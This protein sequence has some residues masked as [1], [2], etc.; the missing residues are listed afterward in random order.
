[1]RHGN[2]LNHL[3]RKSA[4]RKALMMNLAINLIEHKHIVTTTAKAKALRGYVEPLITKSKDNTTHS[5]RLVFS[6]LKNKEAVST[7]FEEVAEKIATRAGGYT[8]IIKLEPRRGDAAEM[9]LIELVDFSLLNGGETATEKGAEK[10]ATKRT[11]RGSKKASANPN[12]DGGAKPKVDIK[13]TSSPKQGGTNMPNKVRQ[14]RSGD[15]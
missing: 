3:G 15:A 10:A 5:R 12:I 6:Q 8:R 14:R 4:H 7:L 13:K 9:A 2:K 11:R 1:M